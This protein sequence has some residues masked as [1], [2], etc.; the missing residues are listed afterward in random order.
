MSGS[1]SIKCR[2]AR[3]YKRFNTTVYRR[4]KDIFSKTDT[5][6][7]QAAESLRV[8][9]EIDE[10]ARESF[11]PPVW[12]TLIMGLSFGVVTF[13]YGAMRHENM[14]ALGLIISCV[15]LLLVYLTHKYPTLDAVGPETG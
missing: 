13:S 12:L 9:R 5:D 14:W 6:R 11:R 10:Q 4:P 15:V 3:E 1:V 8:L 7:Q 2:C